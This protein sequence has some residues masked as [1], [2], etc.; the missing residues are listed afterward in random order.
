MISPHINSIN[1]THY[2][3]YTSF[4]TYRKQGNTISKL[5]NKSQPSLIRQGKLAQR[6]QPSTKVVKQPDTHNTNDTQPTKQTS[7]PRNTKI[8]KQRMSKQHTPASQRTA[9]EIVRREQASRVHRITQRDVHEQALHHDE[10][11][12]TVDSNTD[13]R[14]DPVDRGTRRP[15]KQ[16]QTDGGTDGCWQC[17]NETGFLDWES[18]AHDARVHPEVQVGEVDCDTEDARDQDTQED[19]ADLAEIHVV[20]DRV[21]EGEYLEEGV[22]DA[23]D[24]GG[25]DLDEE[26]GGVL[27]GDFQ[28]LDQGVDGYGGDFHVAL[29][30]LGLGHEAVVVVDLAEALGAAE[31]D[32]CAAGLR[33]EEEH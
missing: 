3:L 27:D 15:G 2:L 17:G 19:Q 6:A 7:S 23:V 5:P 4:L 20:I 30:D 21:D 24:D 11:G 9:E 29:V 25:V 32:G 8:L 18:E 31:E 26:H 16:E 22:V 12:R 33:E 10:H 14:R 28:G 13:G 1:I